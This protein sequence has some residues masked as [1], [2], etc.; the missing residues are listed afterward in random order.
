MSYSVKSL[1]KQVGIL[2]PFLSN[3]AYN[4][5]KE[6]SVRVQLVNCAFMDA[7]FVFR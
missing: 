2:Y 5:Y 7:F 4:Y 1:S 6:V 3:F